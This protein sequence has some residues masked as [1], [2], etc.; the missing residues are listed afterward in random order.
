M[1]AKKVLP[2][3]TN[4]KTKSK[5]VKAAPTE[6]RKGSMPEGFTRINTGG[7]PFHDFGENPVLEGY[8][9]ST[10]TVER[11][12]GR[13]NQTQTI[14]TVLL[15]DESMV[16]VGGCYALD[17]L[18]EGVTDGSIEEGT[19]IYI[20]FLGIKA[21]TGSKTVKLFQVGYAGG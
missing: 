12:K 9:V 15:E 20:E 17:A 16:D 5:A 19:A 11:K 13:G 2:K 4:T 14:L 1:T 7:N 10:R 3:T 18:M 8:A 6:M 21:L